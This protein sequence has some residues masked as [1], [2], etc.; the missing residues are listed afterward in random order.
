MPRAGTSKPATS[1]LRLNFKIGYRVNYGQCLGVLGSG[2]SLGN[3]D[4]RRTVKMSWTD[5]DYWTVELTV[6]PG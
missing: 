3:W 5:G 2:D 6:A 4:P 1:T